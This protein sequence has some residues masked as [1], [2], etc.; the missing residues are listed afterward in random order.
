[1]ARP[2]LHSPSSL[3]KSRI[4]ECALQLIDE[5]GLP[6]FSLRKVAK[7][8]NVYPAA[9]YWHFPNLAALQAGIVAHLQTT[10]LPLL[11]ENWQQDLKNLFQN[12]RDAIQ[13]HPNL[14][15]LVGAQL[16][17]NAA[18]EWSQVEFILQVL[19]NAGFK[20]KA[21][22]NAYNTVVA[23]MTGFVTLEFGQLPADEEEDWAK[24]IQQRL[25][26]LDAKI[27]PQLAK[28]LPLMKNQA[29]ITRWQNGATQPLD[30]A[31]EFHVDTLIEGL[32][33]QLARSEQPQ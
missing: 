4:L 9:L 29:F 30:T 10:L 27:T 21:L 20:E 23:G 11:S 14:A 2:P 12:Y 6:S 28:W 7:A 22:V 19:V 18:V 8:L 17:A 5:D 32:K 1:M 16:T 26:L 13:Q 25:N 24:D 15:P 3:S 33:A 31:F